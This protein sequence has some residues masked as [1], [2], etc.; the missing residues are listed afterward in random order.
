MTIKTTKKDEVLDITDKIQG[1]ID[2][3]EIESGVANIFAKHTTC[4]VTTSEFANDVVKDLLEFLREVSP[5]LDYEHDP[6]HAPDHILSS[7]IGPSLSVPIVD[8]RLSLGT[9]QRIVLVEL[10]GPKEREIE[11]SLQE[12]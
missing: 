8:G 10:N 2:E 12:A 1:L 7:I 3:E 11:I 6:K 4:A 5:K 9:W